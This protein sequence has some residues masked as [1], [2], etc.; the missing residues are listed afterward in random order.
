MPRPLSAAFRVYRRVE[1]SGKLRLFQL[2]SVTAMPSYSRGSFLALV[3]VALGADSVVADDKPLK[4]GEVREFEIAAG[5]KM[6][7]CWIPPGQAQLGSSK[8]E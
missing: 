8:A 5:V 2:Q 7:F 6:K 1:P 3:I 4:P